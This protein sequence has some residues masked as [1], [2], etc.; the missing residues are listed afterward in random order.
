MVILTFI[1]KMHKIKK[2]KKLLQLLILFKKYEY[3]HKP[4]KIWVVYGSEFYNRTM[5]L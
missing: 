2:I 4:N 1:F 5:K 3:G